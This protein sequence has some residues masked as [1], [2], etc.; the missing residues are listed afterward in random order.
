M[1]LTG[2]GNDGARG[3]AR[4]QR[5][6]G[7]VLIQQPD[8]AECRD[9]PAAA[10]CE[11]PGARTLDIEQIAAFIARIEGGARRED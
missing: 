1:I 6:G 11:A 3:V 5:A 9:M 2:K 10:L 7:S 4:I 8:T